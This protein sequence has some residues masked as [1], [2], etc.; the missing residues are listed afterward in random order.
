MKPLTSLA[1]AWQSVKAL[2]ASGAGRENPRSKGALA[3]TLGRF[4]YAQGFTMAARAGHV[5][6]WPVSFRPVSH[7]RSSRHPTAVRSGLDGSIFH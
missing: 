7:P 6:A 1:H 2:D 4:F 5:S 3:P